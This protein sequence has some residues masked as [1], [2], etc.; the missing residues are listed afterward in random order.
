MLRKLLR[1]CY[2]FPFSLEMQGG[3]ESNR[4]AN[5][6]G[7]ESYLH[8]LLVGQYFHISP[9]LGQFAIPM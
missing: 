7:E 1:L 3:R 2:S 6:H 4:E 8:T 9:P 5:F